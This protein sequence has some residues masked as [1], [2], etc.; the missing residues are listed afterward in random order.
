[1]NKELQIEQ[2]HLKNV[3]EQYQ[4][5]LKKEELRKETLPSI[6]KGDELL[7]TTLMAKT[8]HR[9]YIMENNLDKPY[10]A[11]IDFKEK[12]TDELNKCYIGKVGEFDED[13][14]IITID[15]RA[16]I[17]SLYYDGNIGPASYLSPSG[18]I[19]GELLIKRQ[20]EIEKGK[21]ISYQDVDTVSSDELLKPY[22][23]VS[24]DNRLKNIVSSIQK[25]QNDIIRMPV[26]ED[27]IVQGVA[28]SG[29]TTVALHRIA[30]LVYNNR[31]IIDPN[32]YMVIGPNK[33]FLNYI[34]NVLPDLDVTD[35]TQWT[36]EECVRFWIKEK[37]ILQ[38]DEEVA[39]SSELKKIK[40]TM[41]YK[42][43]LDQYL[44]EV[45][46]NIIP[47]EDFMIKGY[48]IIS[49]KVMRSIY[50]EVD[51]K[52]YFNIESIINRMKIRMIKYIN[53][54]REEIL[55]N[56]ENQ[57]LNQF[58][59][60]NDKEEQKKMI[61]DKE[62]VKKE[63]SKKTITFINNYF[64]PCKIKILTL[65]QTFVEKMDQYLLLDESQKKE[66]AI[67]L[68]NL[69]RKK[70]GF[71][72]LA[73]ILYIAYHWYD[74]SEY[75][76]YRYTVIDEAQD[77]GEFH[78]Y[79][80]KKLLPKS[81][82]SIFGDLAQSIYGN[83]SIDN[84]DQVKDIY[85]DAN[86]MYLLKSYRTTIEIMEEAN[87]I[88][89]FIGMNTATPV[90]R[91]GNKVVYQQEQNRVEQIKEKIKEYQ[92]QG[93]DSI[94]IITR[95]KEAAKDLAKVL[96]VPLITDDSLSYEGGVSVLSSHLA[97]GLEFDAVIL[98]DISKENYAPQ[99]P[100]DMKLLYVAM[101]RALHHLFI[102]YKEDIFASL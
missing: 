4:I 92:Q 62:F 37:F 89:K 32:Q 65:Y 51:Q 26:E 3:I 15:W 52:T 57:L 9:I 17:A 14:R 5:I 77:W 64:I 43:A 63:I 2:D 38:S 56:I 96:K 68:A 35:V 67:T 102:L 78:F 39:T 75:K 82:F 36:F 55:M 95:T 69:N 54:H 1:M 8:I 34:S 88:L 60:T 53:D 87:K 7:L 74:M 70:V 31:N 33:F 66:Q 30:Y 61:Q 42:K 86:Q 90:I 44:K 100:L 13:N 24:V 101:T 41:T 6:Y 22:L 27:L 98:V 85:H 59:K 72:D 49:K 40:T 76:R 58:T 80:I 18:M 11:R 84:W 50:E 79:V 25:E 16:P 28:G 81:H 47:I 29:K 45:K 12:K 23:G 99:N 91:H 21:L 46:G 20:F 83:R 48:K 71:E 19:E 93:H 73:G 10:F 94:A 97:K